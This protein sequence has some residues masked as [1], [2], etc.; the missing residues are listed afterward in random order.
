MPLVNVSCSY[1]VAACIVTAEPADYP[2]EKPFN[3]V[4]S[5]PAPFRGRTVI[6][7]LCH[8]R[9]FFQ[10][11]WQTD[12]SAI[13]GAIIA[14]PVTVC[15]RLIPG[16]NQVFPRAC[17]RYRLKL[18]TLHDKFQRFLGHAMTIQNQYF[19]L[20]TGELTNVFI[21]VD[22]PSK[23]RGPAVKD[24]IHD[25]D[26]G[27]VEISRG[28][29]EALV[30]IEQVVGRRLMRMRT[31]KVGYSSHDDDSRKVDDV[32]ERGAAEDFERSVI[33]LRNGTVHTTAVGQEGGEV[34]EGLGEYGATVVDIGSGDVA[35]HN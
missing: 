10:L 15:G 24:T 3:M 20:M 5:Y 23:C 34:A 27:E 9:V 7:T 1:G 14:F 12:Q 16:R 25:L 21:R 28:R 29:L 4:L 2:P 11:A 13:R 31:I 26:A 32:M 17:R 8:A 33:F 35:I 19:R 6:G 30:R 18:V 22:S